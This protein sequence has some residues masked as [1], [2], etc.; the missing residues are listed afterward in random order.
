MLAK[1]A[2]DDCFAALLSRIRIRQ[3]DTEYESEAAGLKTDL[4]SVIN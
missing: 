1:T 3:N 2:E 4:S